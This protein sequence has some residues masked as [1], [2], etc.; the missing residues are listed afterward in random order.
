L[1]IS[2]KWAPWRGRPV[3]AP[4]PGEALALAETLRVVG[5]PDVRKLAEEIERLCRASPGLQ[6]EILRRLAAHRDAERILPAARVSRDKGRGFPMT[7]TS[8]MTAMSTWRGT[9]TRTSLRYRLQGR[10]SIGSGVT[11]SAA[12]PGDAAATMHRFWQAPNEA[13]AFVRHMPTDKIGRLFLNGRKPVQPDP[14]HLAA[15]G[16]HAGANRGDRPASPDTSGA[17]WTFLLEGNGK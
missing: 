1:P 15:H 11:Q 13:D 7:S 3:D 17:L 4:G 14:D 8:S 16:T 12:L 10:T 5:N 6:S 9:P 2:G